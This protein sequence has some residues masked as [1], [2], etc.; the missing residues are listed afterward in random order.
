[1]PFPPLQG[2][3]DKGVINEKENDFKPDAHLTSRQ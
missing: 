3:E 1:M 2:Q